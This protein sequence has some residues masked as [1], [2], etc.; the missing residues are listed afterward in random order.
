[1]SFFVLKLMLFSHLILIKN[2]MLILMKP[3]D[4]NQ[5]A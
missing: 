4:A 2:P 1:M 5:N 3:L